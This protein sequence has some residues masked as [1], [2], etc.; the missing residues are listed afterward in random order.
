MKNVF[1]ILAML[2][3]V[4][5]LF[6]LVACSKPSTEPNNDT[7]VNANTSNSQ[8]T[9]GTN[10]QETD[11]TNEQKTVK[12]DIKELSGDWKDY[13]FAVDEHVF[14][15]PVLCGELTAT[16]GYTAVSQDETTSL[17]AGNAKTILLVNSN[18]DGI[19]HIDVVNKTGEKAAFDACTVFQVTQTVTQQ[20][21]SGVA[22]SIT[23]G[24]SIGS[25]TSK[26]ALLS[27]LGE[28]VKA[29]EYR[30]TSQT[31]AR[32]DSDTYTWAEYPD[33]LDINFTLVEMN[34][35]TGI[36]KRIQIDNSQPS[37]S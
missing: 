27:T 1:K 23:G 29:Y 26:D 35:H 17:N 9:D 31:M 12:P 16:T 5:M 18:G 8:D 15:L 4:V 10:G 24:F 7:K 22:V 19:C 13:K 32:F 34:I 20:E 25:A 11:G 21:M 3:A 14:S 2:I 37:N 33:C 30:S 6:S 36:V 28:P